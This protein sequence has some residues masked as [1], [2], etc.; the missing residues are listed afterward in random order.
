MRK[1]EKREVEKVEKKG[2]RTEVFECGL[3]S[4]GVVGKK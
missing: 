2:L 1:G 4:I 3:R